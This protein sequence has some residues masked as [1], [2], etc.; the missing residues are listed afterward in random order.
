VLAAL[1]A[2]RDCGALPGGGPDSASILVAGGP[3]GSR[4][5]RSR[6]RAWRPIRGSMP[7]RV[8]ARWPCKARARTAE[9]Q[10][11]APAL[12]AMSYL[13]L[14]GC[15]VGRLCNRGLPGHRPA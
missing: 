3:P 14:A 11:P 12:I 13:A 7:L 9:D 10:L 15:E 8:V 6:A 4:A 5:R 1:V 2:A